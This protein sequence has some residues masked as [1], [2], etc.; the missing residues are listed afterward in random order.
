MSQGRTWPL[1]LYA[2]LTRL[3]QPWAGG[4]LRARARRGKEDAARL[5][6]RL[7]L[8]SAPRP[9]GP[10]AWLH[11]A[12]VGES[13]SLLPLIQAL[14][15]ERPEAAVLVTSGTL[16][17]AQMMA[18][19]LPPGAL[20][21]FAPVDAPAAVA[22]FLDHW[23]PDLAVRVESELWP[24]LLLQTRRRGTRMALLSAKLSASSARNWA[25][26][27][28][29]ASALLGVFD[30][31]LAQ[32]AVSAQRLEALGARVDGLADLKYGAEPLP[33]PK[34]RLKALT[35]AIGA[36]PVIVAASTHP[37]EDALI[38][39]AFASIAE[40]PVA[41]LLVIVPRHPDRGPEVAQLARDQAY[42]VSLASAGEPV[43]HEPVHV[44][45]TLGELGLWYRL[46]RLAIIGGGFVHG[47]GGHNPL[48]PARLSCPFA[49]GP[50]IANWASTYSGL[51]EAGAYAPID[52]VA[53]LAGLMLEA[54]DGAPGLK[55]RAARA[56]AY[57][58]A[59]DAEARA[60]PGRVLGLLP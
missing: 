38:L 53:S 16:T 4:A 49:S 36:R 37:G 28:R 60:V 41:P 24:N 34:A 52:D 5:G 26:F 27:P 57:V 9:D 15:A 46:A 7:G 2:G 3:A 50:L 25:R 11:G 30:L 33:A 18:E 55:Q 56:L 6:E 1:T 29:S 47:V 40:A 13:L 44:A 51:A 17:S 45:D 58:K 19:R 12:S 54:V 21:Q 42:A 31:I 22:R 20:H 59:R 10:L 39:A 43:G 8:A 14:R 48:E 35:S 23:R 32:D